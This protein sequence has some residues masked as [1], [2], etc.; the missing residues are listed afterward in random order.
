MLEGKNSTQVSYESREA[1]SARKKLTIHDGNQGS[2][3]WLMKIDVVGVRCRRGGS[4]ATK[5]KGIGRVLDDTRTETTYWGSRQMG[6]REEMR[7]N[8]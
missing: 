8:Q 1:R 2:S 6:Y 4:S 5:R 7:G 3:G